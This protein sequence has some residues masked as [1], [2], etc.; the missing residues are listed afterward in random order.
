MLISDR[1]LAWVVDQI[2]RAYLRLHRRAPFRCITGYR[3]LIRTFGAS[4]LRRVLKQPP[5]AVPEA[6]PGDV[7]VHVLTKRNECLFA[8]W[9]CRSL[10][11]RL[12]RPLPVF[13]HDDGSLTPS[14]I[15]LLISALPGVRVVTRAA[16]DR[17]ARE[18]LADL[19]KC[20]RLRQS[21]VLT[22]KLFDPWIVQK[23]GDLILLDSDVLFFRDPGEVL[24]WLD[25]PASRVNRWNVESG[26]ATT[27]ATN[28]E[29]MGA[30]MED[31]PAP[32]INSGLGLVT[33]TSI[34]FS[35]I[36]SWLSGHE[37]PDDWLIEQRLYGRLSR[38]AGMDSLPPEYHVANRD[39]L[40]PAASIST[41]YVGSLRGFFI[42]EGIPRLLNGAGRSQTAAR[43]LDHRSVS[44]LAE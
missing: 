12:K 40:R 18:Q 33:R 36:E 32:E 4:L 5:L 8:L 37:R 21:N 7:C 35:A 30:K 20:L 31:P 43:N 15:A 23:T 41:H 38:V 24:H 14:H 11:E 25:E 26:V 2:S 27:P 6:A 28:R 9:A 34:C 44:D 17:L 29:R 1:L 42:S 3:V 22:L 39:G 10:L 19:P 16:A 13:I